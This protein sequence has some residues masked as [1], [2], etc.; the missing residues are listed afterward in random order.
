M[1]DV[2]I[3]Y[4]RSTAAQAHQV[5][6]A[7]RALGYGVWRDDELPAHRAYADVIE[8]RL[9]AARAAVVIWSAEAVRSEWVQSEADTARTDHKLVQLNVD[10]SRLPRPFDRVQCADLTGWAGD[11]DAPG[12]R[13][14]VASI[15]ELVGRQGDA[16]PSAAISAPAARAREPL[17]A[18][19]PFDNLSSDPEMDFFSDGVSEEILG[20]L[21]RGSKLKVVGRTS[22]FQFRGD[23]KPKA[24]AAL[25]AT[26]VLDGSIR[27]AAA[28]VRISA[29]LVESGTQASLWSDRYDRG[30]E[31]IFAVQDEISEAIAEALNTTFF[32]VKI[33]PV[34]PEAYDLYL[35]GRAHAT[36]VEAREANVAL[37]ERATRR[38][39]D[40]ADG[41]GA[42]AYRRSWLLQDEPY[43]ER[44]A[45]M[46]ALEDEV[47]KCLSIDPDNL[48][49]AIAQYSLFDKFGDFVRMEPL[50]R[51][52]AAQGANN[53]DVQF[54]LAGHSERLGRQGEAIGYAR[55]ANELD[56]MDMLAA[57]AAGQTLWRAGRHAEGR[58]IMERALET[59]PDFHHNAAQL[60][61]SYAYEQDWA[62]V[63]R[64]LDPAR[65][66]QYPL[67]ELRV[68]PALVAA[69][70]DTSGELRRDLVQRIG[71]RARQTG[72]IDFV[73]AIYV[74]HLGFV[75]E[76]YAMLDAAK[77]GPAGTARD[78]LGPN[79]YSTHLLWATAFPELRTDIRFVTLCARLGLVEYWTATQK[80]PDCADQVPYDFRAEC[81]RLA[82]LPL[83]EPFFDP[84][85]M[86]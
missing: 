77:L 24:A 3:S 60:A 69:M 65:L 19:L 71:D 73:I 85:N 80:W 9:Q 21:T 11:L 16:P 81:E 5:A 54:I 27:R 1:S 75:D 64:L 57:A 13:K 50:V 23:N 47:A 43:A 84:A 40:F 56:P 46:A 51:R 28:R 74:A 10:G 25:N 70:R 8:E 86:I 79:A 66:Q 63:D 58:A 67:R 62:A 34:D 48:L 15:A 29:H 41:W 83:K 44:G 7:L 4:A 22:S 59:W 32:P 38:A 17:L 49:A 45:T 31:D 42:L 26:H 20:R 39:P 68:V 12:W 33:A 37:L 36:S 78:A 82:P 53:A 30:L 76:A 61:V 2:F 35:R 18:V 72:H 55:R 14:V 52:L 6:E